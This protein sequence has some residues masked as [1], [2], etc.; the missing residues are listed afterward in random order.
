MLYTPWFSCLGPVPSAIAARHTQGWQYLC[1]GL[2]VVLQH[3]SSP[4]QQARTLQGQRHI[5]QLK[6]QQQTLP[7][8]QVP[9]SAC[10]T[11]ISSSLLPQ[12]PMPPSQHPALTVSENRSRCLVYPRQCKVHCMPDA[13][14]ESSHELP[15]SSVWHCPGRQARTCT[16]CSFVMGAP[17]AILF[18]A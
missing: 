4:G 7:V 11:M 6:L 10:T 17:K 12:R 9:T 1:E 13:P 14:P 16:A 2:P 3:S 15:T 5:C 18:S 8:V